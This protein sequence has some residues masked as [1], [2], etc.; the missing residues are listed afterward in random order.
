MCASDNPM[1]AEKPQNTACA[2]DGLMR[3][4]P[5]DSASTKPS[6]DSMAIQASMVG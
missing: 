4:M 6:G 5:N 3:L 1:T 2:I